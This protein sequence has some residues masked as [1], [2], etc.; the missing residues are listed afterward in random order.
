MNTK[1][2]HDPH[3]AILRGV[4]GGGV[5]GEGPGPPGEPKKNPK[6]AEKSTHKY[7]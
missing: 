3:V 7:N 2:S 6:S 4:E 5:S 1:G